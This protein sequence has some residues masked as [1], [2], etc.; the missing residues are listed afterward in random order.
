[1]STV[2]GAE[3][4]ERPDLASRLERWGGG[5]LRANLLGLLAHRLDWGPAHAMARPVVLLMLLL[6]ATLALSADKKE[7][8]R[9]EGE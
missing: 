7:D 8:N 9:P 1:M 6:S 5:R 4:Q 2:L 3:F